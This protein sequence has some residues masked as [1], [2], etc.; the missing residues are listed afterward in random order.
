MTDL[1]NE[2]D[3][4]MEGCLDQIDVA[5]FEKRADEIIKEVNET[6][7]LPKGMTLEIDPLGDL[8]H[9]EGFVYCKTHI[10]SPQQVKEEDVATAKKIQTIAVKADEA[11]EVR[12][13][14]HKKIQDL[15]TP[16]FPVPAQ[17]EG[18]KKLLAWSK[19]QQM[20]DE[21][22]MEKLYPLR[23]WAKKMNP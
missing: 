23:E 16:K 10:P 11:W 9:E 6:G 1:N 18:M 8:D 20:R 2:N 22:F 7:E 21:L 15:T 13:K 19:R 12:Q 5:A 3:P 4:T 17:A 14:L